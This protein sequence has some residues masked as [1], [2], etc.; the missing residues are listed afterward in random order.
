MR[1]KR[2]EPLENSDKFFDY[3]T[4]L[5]QTENLNKKI[6]DMEQGQL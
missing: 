5:I 6:T 4:D 2:F 1:K 3:L